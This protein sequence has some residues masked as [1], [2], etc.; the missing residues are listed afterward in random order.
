M[1]VCRQRKRRHNTLHPQFS[2][3]FTGPGGDGAYL[4]DYA[5]VPVNLLAMTNERNKRID[6]LPVA[7]MLLAF[8]LRLYLFTRDTRVCNELLNP[9]STL[10]IFAST[11]LSNL[12]AEGGPITH[13]N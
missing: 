9:P 2:P 5:I 10:D 12:K 7:C 11:L 4:D 13:H 6:C 1:R 3:Y 8:C